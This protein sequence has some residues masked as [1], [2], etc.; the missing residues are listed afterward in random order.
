MV[1]WGPKYERH[2]GCTLTL[3]PDYDDDE[4]LAHISQELITILTLNNLY[5]IVSEDNPLMGREIF[6]HVL[7]FAK[8]I[9][10]SLTKIFVCGPPPSQVEGMLFF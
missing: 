4:K 3:W 5:I 7:Q 10:A 6:K 8:N 1:S 2:V 9:F